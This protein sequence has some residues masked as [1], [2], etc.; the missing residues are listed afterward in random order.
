MGYIYKIINDIN[1]KVYIGQTTL[2]IKDRFYQHINSAQN[3]KINTHLYSAMRKY[4]TEHFQIQLIEEVDDNLLS[5]REQYWIKYYNSYKAGYN[6]TIGGEGY[7]LY[8]REEIYKLWDD[9]LAIYEI[10][11]KLKCGNTVLWRT[12]KN[13]PNYSKEESYKRAQKEHRKEKIKK[14]GK[15]IGK[16]TL[17]GI[18]IDIYNGPSNCARSISDDENKVKIIASNISKVCNKKKYSNTV[19][20]Y[21][22]KYE[23]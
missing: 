22:W 15:K 16:Y 23:E 4:G 17:D 7:V 2:K 8:N 10:A 1:N 18:L 9:G 21:I 19:Y 3:N 20:G 12:L 13:Y 14:Y 6:S 11:N 5:K